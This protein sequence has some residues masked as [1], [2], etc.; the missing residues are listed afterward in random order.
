MGQLSL[1]KYY[2]LREL[3]SYSLAFLRSPR[4]TRQLKPQGEPLQ[5]KAFLTIKRA[6]VPVTGGS[7]PLTGGGPFPSRGHWFPLRGDPFPLRALI[8]GLG[9]GDFNYQGF[10]VSLRI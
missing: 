1:Q 5:L 4:E 10:G 9:P 6:S 3:G 7:V 2:N 8:V